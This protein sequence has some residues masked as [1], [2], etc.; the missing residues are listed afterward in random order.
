M[1]VIMSVAQTNLDNKKF[2]TSRILISV[3]GV[4]LLRNCTELLQASIGKFCQPLRIVARHL[5]PNRFIQTATM[6]LQRIKL[7]FLH[8]P[9][10]TKHRVNKC[11]YKFL[12]CKFYCPQLA[13]DANE[14]IDAQTL[15]RVAQEVVRIIYG[16][17]RSKCF[18][19][20]QLC[21]SLLRTPWVY[22]HAQK[23]KAILNLDQSRVL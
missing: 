10:I 19:I 11:L 23:T 6:L 15:G 8:H 12:R 22:Y 7:Y 14:K 5:I 13:N 3:I 20:Q 4:I 2:Q 9:P 18:H 16:N 17:D 21:N 1:R